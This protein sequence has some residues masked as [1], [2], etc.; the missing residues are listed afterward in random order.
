MSGS[1]FPTGPGGPTVNAAQGPPGRLAQDAGCLRRVLDEDTGFQA[2]GIETGAVLVCLCGLPGT[3]KS[4]FAREL[5]GKLLGRAPMVVLETDRLR[6]VL[7]A[8]PKYTRGEHARV[9]KVCH[10]LIAEYLAQGRGVIFDATNLT[11]DARTPLY[12]IAA[13]IGCPL[14]LV[15]FTAPQ[16]LVKKRLAQRVPGRNKGDFSDA[17][18]QIHCRMR[19]FE[20]PI[21]R[22]HIM[23]D[24]SQD[25][26][27]ALDRV[28]NRVSNAAPE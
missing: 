8:K 28:I 13:R 18:W 2:S 14:V 22:P 26:S 17:T 4:Y 16:D 20:Q 5:Q 12:D 6:K 23:V 9:F 19:P 15:G 7:V 1:G 10:L 25:I 11:E 27:W 21:Q 24:T 3:G